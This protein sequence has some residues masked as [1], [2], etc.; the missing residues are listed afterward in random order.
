VLILRF[1]KEKKLLFGSVQGV[2]S[3]L[4]CCVFLAPLV[5]SFFDVGSTVLTGLGTGYWT[6]WLNLLASNMIANLTAVPAIVTFAVD[7]IPWLRKAS[8]AQHCEAA[9]LAV[10]TAVVSYLVFARGTLIGHGPALICAPIPFLIWAAI[11]FGPA[12]LSFTT[13]EVTII[14][15]WSALQGKGIFEYSSMPNR[16]VSVHILLGLLLLPLMLMAAALAE[17]RSK[18]KALGTA[19]NMLIYAHEQEYHSI[20][21]ELQTDI[22]G[23]MTL[24]SMGFDDLRASCNANTSPL[25]DK[26]YDQVFDALNAILN[27]SHKIHPF[28]VEYLGL[29]RA[30]TKLCR[31]GSAENGITIT[32]SVPKLPLDLPLGTSLRIFRVAQLALQNIQNRKAKT[33]TFELI[34]NVEQTLL[35]ISDDGDRTD[36]HGRE[37]L[38]LACIQE[39]VLSLSGTFKA[40]STPHGGM[41][42]ECS[43][44]NRS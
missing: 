40:S 35:R 3:F 26:L 36:P 23:Q 27:L 38:W 11:R 25:L 44:A 34:A 5:A 4:S 28:K 9:I 29:T 24:I 13:L 31:D 19:R 6:L 39:Q 43:V 18:E 32:C 1:Q 33:A 21:R 7:G 41:V 17:R 2:V 12:G 22:A 42:I 20:A 8:R 30:L 15:V 37:A 16:V 10:S 14:S